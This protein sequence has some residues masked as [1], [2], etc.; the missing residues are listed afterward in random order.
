MIPSFTGS[1]RP[2]R[3][4]NLSGRN[5][6]PFAVHPTSSSIS[7]SQSANNAVVQAQ[8]ERR[9][10]QL[11]R[12]RP[13]AAVKIQKVW[14]GYRERTTVRDQWRI[15]WDNNERA[16][17]ELG[18]SHDEDMSI[19][20]NPAEA[21]IRSAESKSNERPPYRT[22]EI[23]FAQ[24]KLLVQFASAEKRD[25]LFRVLHFASRYHPSLRPTVKSSAKRWDTP[26]SLLARLLAS[27]VTKSY[28]P[29]LQ[30][31]S[32]E[33]VNLLRDTAVAIPTRISPSEYY[34]A[35]ATEVRR[36][37]ILIHTERHCQLVQLAIQ[38]LL[39]STELNLQKSL[40]VYKAFAREVLTIPELS[41]HLALGQVSITY[42]T[43]TAAMVENLSSF[44]EDHESLLWLLAHF[45]YFGRKRK[46]QQ[47]DAEYVKVISTMT[48]VLAT[49]IESRIASDRSFIEDDENLNKERDP[50]LP[51]FIEEQLS[52]LVNQESISS[53]LVHLQ[54]MSTSLDEETEASRQTSALA[55]YVLTLLRVFPRR[56]DEIRMW[57]FLGGA[58]SVSKDKLP[59]IKFFYEASR[60]SKVYD[61]I[62]KDPQQAISLLRTDSSS[63]SRNL[64][65]TIESRNRHWRVILIFM[66]LYAFV[67][68]M[69]DDE[70]FLS[71]SASSRGQDQESWTR[72]S[73]LG[74][75]QISDL[76]GFLKHL[77]FAMY[78]HTSE[79]LGVK[80]V[81]H[82]DSIA[83]YFSTKNDQALSN[84][85]ENSIR[86]TEEPHLAGMPGMTLAY[87]KGMVT[88]LLRMIYERDSRRKFLPKGHWL[89]TKYFDM[90]EFISAVVREEAEKQM[91]EESYEAASENPQ[92][93][94]NDREAV[95]LV[96]TSRTQRLRERQRLD[97]LQYQRA[98]QRYL[99]SVTPRLEILQNMPFFIPFATRVHIFRQIIHMDQKK[100]RGGY[101][102]PDDWR[103]SMMTHNRDMSR[104]RATVHR[105][106]IFDDAFEQFFALGEG[107]K[108]PIQIKFVD[109]FGTEEEGIDGG[110]VTKEFLT[111]VTNETFNAT[112]GLEFFVEN[113]QHLLYPN[114]SAVDERRD[115]L[116]VAGLK[117]TD[118]EFTSSMRDLLRRY[119]F[120]GRIIAKCLYEGILVDVHFAPFFL[121][122]WALTGGNNAATRESSYRA[123]I[124]DLRDLDEGLYQGLLK[125]KNYPGNVEDF[126]LTF[127]IDDTIS[128]RL[129][130]SRSGTRTITRELRPGGSSIPVTNENR[131]VYISYVARHRL[132]IQ[133]HAQ[134]S[135]F[136]RGL[137]TIVSPSWLS[138][139]N[140]SELQTLLSG[141]KSEISIAD[142]RANTQYGGVYV[143][144]DDGKEHPTISLFWNVLMGLEDADRRKVL[145]FVTSTP[146][147]PLLG[148][149]MLNPRFSIRDA[150]NDQS[151]LPTTSTC[152][153]LLKLPIYKTEAVLK[154]RLLYSVNAGAGFNL[155]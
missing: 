26:L 51:L 74:I 89:M 71:G 14:R 124:N 53:L 150:G 24:L 118:P 35:M 69:T 22:E 151:R 144:G 136:L 38:T 3:Q 91:I 104:H 23:C 131:L 85:Q 120:L 56:G 27:I 28:H 70:E 16:D 102:D 73:A 132:Q 6:N 61:A 81:D 31:F 138:M 43:L 30:E 41:T 114:P 94:D 15:Q 126:S 72:Q 46:D 77:A 93:E 66:E 80:D 8:R 47:P 116:T 148:F 33:F 111:S 113:D 57:L 78:W 152:V 45:I 52:S 17:L 137:G 32:D 90:D 42:K 153:N 146:R 117:E 21:T 49:D 44:R 58:T 127:E 121:L 154:E 9:Q 4:V 7:S 13:P 79:I 96:G 149:E 39:S 98:R 86:K 50:P 130:S 97:E 95:N 133:P 110:G 155:S 108:E 147:A 62:K 19:E 87:L 119:E 128:Q 135:A 60:S 143:I 12:E 48:S 59:A 92:M 129:A 2:R 107:L 11:E 123:N 122:K 40:L 55:T 83:A 82:G 106:S 99:A 64:K 109:S 25:D 112:N 18:S 65:S 67:L 10:R 63:S 5:T 134:T 54:A 145:K 101:D 76:T 75:E 37:S 141:S 103:F 125:L 139:F 29:L 105:D 142:L 20:S 115:F 34:R 140:Q 84:R 1:A 100:R 36:T 88:G 68:R